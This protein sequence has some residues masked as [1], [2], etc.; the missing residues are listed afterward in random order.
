MRKAYT[1]VIDE[2]RSGPSQDVL[3]LLDDLEENLSIMR[4]DY[5]VEGKMNLVRLISR[6]R[7]DRIQDLYMPRKYRTPYRGFP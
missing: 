2:M 6:S 3:G 7:A 4:R 1:N 5:N